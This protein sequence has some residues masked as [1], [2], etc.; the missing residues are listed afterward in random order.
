MINETFQ[1]HTA[2]PLKT[3]GFV[4]T[5]TTI[6]SEIRKEKLNTT[7]VGLNL[8]F[9]RSKVHLDAAYF[10]TRTTDLIT[11][12]TPSMASGATSFLT[13]IGELQG[14]GVEV[15]L[16]G[17]IVDA[18]GFVWDQ[19][20]NY[21]TNSTIVKSI[22]DDLNEIAVDTYTSVGIYAVVDENFPS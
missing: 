6:D 1:Q 11:R 5:P 21:S 17:T 9:F 15:T 14:S 20:F 2:F 7:E 19:S 16:G 22:K 12:T 4:L 10:L 8:G 3:N 13:N 18:A